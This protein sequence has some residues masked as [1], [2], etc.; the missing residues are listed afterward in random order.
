MKLRILPL[1]LLVLS[2]PARA[3]EPGGLPAQT[4][5]YLT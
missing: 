5:R 3:A 1:S 4:I 2:G